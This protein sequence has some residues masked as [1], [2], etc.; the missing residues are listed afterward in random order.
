MTCFTP[1]FPFGPSL[2]LVCQSLDVTLNRIDGKF[3]PNTGD[4]M[5]TGWGYDRYPDTDFLAK[6]VYGHSGA[7]HRRKQPYPA[8][9]IIEMSLQN[10]SEV[11]YRLLR[12]MH[13]L[14]DQKGFIT[15][16][17]DG[18][19]VFEEAS[20]RTR[21]K[22][23]PGITYALPTEIDLVYYF[24]IFDIQIEEFRLLGKGESDY[25]V[26][27]KAKEFDPDRPVQGDIP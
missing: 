6:T 5:L 11:E 18:L 20:P 22:F 10:L 19:Y 7:S 2:R 8:P 23:N 15:R 17:Y 1:T 16:L 13:L 4:G 26:Y 14:W 9:Q 3:T 24:A 12:G 21:A 27:I 25:S